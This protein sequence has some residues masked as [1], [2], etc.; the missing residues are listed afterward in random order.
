MK[1]VDLIVKLRKKLPC[2][3]DLETFLDTMSQLLYYYYYLSVPT[4]VC[5]EIQSGGVT[6]R[7]VTNV[8]S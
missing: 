3:Q 2:F 5:S 6:A 7:N 4:A 1:P 8:D